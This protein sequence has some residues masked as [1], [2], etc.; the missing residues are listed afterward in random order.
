MKEVVKMSPQ[1][2]PTSINVRLVTPRGAASH[3]GTKS[4]KFSRMATIY[5]SES[6]YTFVF[7]YKR[8]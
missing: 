4:A 5:I 3:F 1:D 2:V 7:L 8:S 6:F